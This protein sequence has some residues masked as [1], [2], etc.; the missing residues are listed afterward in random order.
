MVIRNATMEIAHLCYEDMDGKMHCKKISIPKERYGFK[1]QSFREHM[2]KGRVRV[3]GHVKDP[4]VA[5]SGPENYIEKDYVVPKS[6]MD[7]RLVVGKKVI[8]RVNW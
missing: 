7:V 4:K 5:G 3:V 6:A 8:S 2:G 1:I